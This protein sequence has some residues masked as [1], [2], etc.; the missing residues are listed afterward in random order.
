VKKGNEEKREREREGEGRM[1]EEKREEKGRGK[2]WW[3]F[4]FASTR[5]VP[6]NMC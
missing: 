3:G 5:L 2:K 4:L 6:K 1:G